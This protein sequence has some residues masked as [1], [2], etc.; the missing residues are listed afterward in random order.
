MPI[1]FACGACGKRFAVPIQDLGKKGKCPCGAVIEVPLPP[2]TN[3]PP[4]ATT[5]SREAIEAADNADAGRQNGVLIAVGVASLAIVGLLGFAALAPDRQAETTEASAPPPEAV[6]DQVE[7]AA[8]TPLKVDT[9]PSVG[10]GFSLSQF[11]QDVSGRNNKWRVITDEEDDATGVSYQVEHVDMEGW[12][13]LVTGPRDNLKSVTMTTVLSRTD[14]GDDLHLALAASA[15]SVAS[16]S[17]WTT[18]EVVDWLLSAGINRSAAE[19]RRGKHVLSVLKMGDENEV[20]MMVTV[21]AGFPS[22][23]I[24]AW[25]DWL[26]ENGKA[27]HSGQEADLDATPRKGLAAIEDTVSTA[28]RWSEVDERS[29]LHTSGLA[30]RFDTDARGPRCVV[31]LIPTDSEQGG[32]FQSFLLLVAGIGEGGTDRS[33]NSDRISDWLTNPT[34][35]LSL[36]GGTLSVGGTVDGVVPI[37]IRE[38]K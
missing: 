26:L 12:N 30:V 10:L 9:K 23:D 24:P 36:I 5:A 38:S 18:G 16:Y 17:P 33:V 1:K 31:E 11:K 3:V 6:I 34:Q 21:S 25:D 20:A 32:L 13:W 35:S 29:Y 15:S 28:P 8:A 27:S 14:P 37:T 4:P 7:T 22:R 19:V 2:A